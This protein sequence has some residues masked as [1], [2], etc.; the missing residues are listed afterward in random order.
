MR[1]DQRG[2]G[3]GLVLGR[4]AISDMSNSRVLE[5]LLMYERRIENSMLKTMDELRRRRIMRELEQ[6]REELFR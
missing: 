4:V 1:N 3:P 6:A 5:R 2:S